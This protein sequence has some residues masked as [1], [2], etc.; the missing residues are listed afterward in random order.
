MKLY[1]WVL[2]SLLSSGISCTVAFFLFQFHGQGWLAAIAAVLVFIILSA[3]SGNF[4]LGKVTHFLQVIEV[5]LLNLKDG[6]FALGLPAAKD[7]QLQLLIN[8]FNEVAQS[9]QRGRGSLLQR[10]LLLDRVFETV[11]SALLLVDSRNKVVLCNPAAKHFLG[12]GNA[13]KGLDLDDL[14]PKL[15]P[16][17]A[18][19]IAQQEEVLFTLDGENGEPETWHLSC[20]YFYLNGREHC[21]YH[22]KH[23]TQTLSRTEV[24]TW[25]KVIRVLSHELNNSLAPLISLSHSG[26]LVLAKHTLLETDIQL[27]QKIFTTLGER[28]SHLNEFLGAYAQFSRLPKPL[29]AVIDWPSFL[30]GLQNLIPFSL[31]QS[32]SMRSGFADAG[33]LSQVLINLVKNATEAGSSPAA[34]EVKVSSQGEW[35]KITVSDGGSGMSDEQ[36]K[37]ALLPFYSTKRD[38]TGLGLALCREIVDAHDGRIKLSNKKEGGLEVTIWL[39]AM[40]PLVNIDL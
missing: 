12:H 1:Q 26:K 27:L 9:L 34:T 3:L 15:P 24:D 7:P 10:E 32:I 29:P 22:F 39:P 2:V 23:M 11:S 35:D 4:F 8:L 5:A 14:L 16:P 13:I 19:S 20:E 38:G 6:E 25:K 40:G 17:V 28:A 21:L 36:L 37:L 30:G 31:H 18:E 33:Q